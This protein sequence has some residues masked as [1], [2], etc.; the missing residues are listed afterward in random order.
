MER[1]II[2]LYVAGSILLLTAGPGAARESAAATIV[3][4]ESRIS[5]RDA[6]LALARIL[7]YDEATI[8]DSLTEYRMLLAQSSDDIEVMLETAQVLLRLKMSA[9]AAVMLTGIHRR[10]P[11]NPTVL[12]AMA[13][14]ECGRGHAKACRGLYLDALRAAGD[15]PDLKLR[16]ADRMNTWGDFYKAESLYREHIAGH[17]A[18]R[19]TALKLA[20][21][22]ASS[23]RYEESEDI[24]RALIKSGYKDAAVFT[25]LAGTRLLEKD[26]TGSERYAKE[27]LD[28]AP[29]NTEAARILAES[30][31][32]SGKYEDARKIYEKMTAQPGMETTGLINTGKTYLK[33]NNAPE[34]RR[35]FEK[36]Q[37]MD[38]GNIAARFYE[39]W[40]GTVRSPAFLSSVMHQEGLSAADLSEWADLYASHGFLDEAIQCLREAL[41]RDPAYFPA[42]ASLAGILGA[43]HRYDESV[44]LYRA[45]LRDFPDDSKILIGL[46]RV[47]AWSRH[48]DESIALYRKIIGLNP[49]DPV[50]RREMARTAMWAK[51]PSLAMETYEDALS[52]ISG[53]KPSVVPTGGKEK[54]ADELSQP[55]QRLYRSIYLEKEAKKLAY[56]RRF[57][58]SLPVYD[59]L[60]EE[61]PG[62]EEALFDRGQVA[63]ALGLCDLEG[64]AYEKLLA[65]DPLHS[66][67][68]LSLDRQRSRANPSARFDY[69]YWNE[70]GRGDLARITRNRFD[71]T[72]DLP[73]QC[74]YH[75]F[76]KGHRWLEQPDFDHNTYGANGFSVGF[77]GVFNP[78]VKGEA[79]W[80]HKKYD[81][82]DL[83]DRDAG[84]GTL[85]FNVHDSL[86]LGVGYA[87]TDE[88]Y[89]YF[90]IRQ[91]IQADRVFVSFQS[92]IT[93]KLE[94]SGKAEYTGYTDSNSGSFFGLSAGYALTDHPRIF[95]VAM[96]GEFR[97][98]LHDNEYVYLN[99]LLTDIV[100]PYWAPRD[101]TA[102]SIIF[103]WYHDLSKLFIC[104]AEQHYYD[105]K[106]SFGTDS[107][108]NPYAKIEGE[109]NYEFMKH[110]LI[111]IRGMIHTSPEWDATG[112]WALLRYRF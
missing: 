69:S 99:G 83:S 77:A 40:P 95:K 100:H 88:L 86:R 82:T 48:Y 16:F 98:T 42:S 47:L 19:E 41:I 101:Y 97:N 12:A 93:R 96:S 49:L 31:V 109:W 18:D 44:G 55:G 63:C 8:R 53:T 45:L 62:N 35:Y 22:L 36:V 4:H 23:Q 85:W 90:G 84:Y 14:I 64:R 112:A 43:D 29:E 50:P 81:S 102:G 5:D 28:I 3:P 27:A 39:N 106:A 26:F 105:L 108:N 20:R 94:V 73:V 2:L 1:F 103:E 17:P 30:F 111:G 32:S 76:L 56:N 92:D 87:R 7:S 46:A 25:G 9:E 10:D 65:I 33:E 66:L 58:Q 21:T 70:E 38:P 89:N 72:V 104:G 110:W 24:Y 11:S 68:G 79:A 67:A 78:F 74:R 51:N 61:N 6:R 54:E 52:N 80:T 13:D 57:T 59:A 34:A 15:R 91:G 60:I 75:F 37:V 107:E 71:T